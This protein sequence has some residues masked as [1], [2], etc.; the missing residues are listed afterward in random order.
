MVKQPLIPVVLGATATGKTD[1][2][3]ELSKLIDGEVISVD[4]RKVYKGLPIGTA[5]PDGRW[6]DG[7]LVVDGVP[8]H[9]ISCLNPDQPFT[10]GDFAQQAE[11]LIEKIF[12]KG[13]IPV[14]VGGTGF[15]F[16]ALQKGLPELPPRSPALRDHLMARIEKEGSTALHNELKQGD[17]AAAAAIS[18]HDTH[19]IIRALEVLQ[20][21]GQPFS[22]WKNTGRKPSSHSFVVM[23][24]HMDKN[25][26]EKR[27]EQRSKRMLEEGMIE[28]TE[29]V[30]NQGYA[31]TCPALSSFGYREAVEVIEGTLPRSEF[32]PRLIKGTKAYAKR[33]HT[34]FRTQT[35]PTWIDCDEKTSAKEISLKMRAFLNISAS[36]LVDSRQ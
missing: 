34:W 21:T 19:K 32:L 29:A 16:K 33:Q 17:P 6:T 12:Q 18:D 11:V 28:E 4:S 31:K 14:L 27:I 1:A 5:T 8:H 25:T 13:K 10:A 2:G 3:I 20:L 26:I 35:K 22:S 24:L 9:L 7:S 30:L 36:H 15:Y 23:G